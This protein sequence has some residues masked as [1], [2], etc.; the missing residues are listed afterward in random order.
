[1]NG[2]VGGRLFVRGEN[3]TRERPFV[4]CANFFTLSSEDCSM[5]SMLFV[6][7][8]SLSLSFSEYFSIN[9]PML[10]KELVF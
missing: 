2:T 1:M 5:A 10:V 4:R 7:L 8:F 3:G 6:E 9:Y